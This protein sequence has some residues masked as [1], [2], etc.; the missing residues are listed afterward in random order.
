MPEET[1]VQSTPETLDIAVM[2]SADHPS[3]ETIKP[4][5]RN[6]AELLAAFDPLDKTLK[7]KGLSTKKSFDEFVRH[8]LEMRAV[9]SQRGTKRLRGEAGLPNW[10]QYLKDLI[11]E[12]GLSITLRTLYRWLAPTPDPGSAK[13][14]PRSAPKKHSQFTAGVVMSD[15]AGYRSMLINVLDRVEKHREDPMAL[16]RMVTEYREFLATE[17]APPQIPPAVVRKS[18]QPKKIDWIHKKV[19]ETVARRIKNGTSGKLIKIKP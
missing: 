8:L 19:E 16:M 18:P 1:T 15:A 2:S 5:F 13:K 9:L 3:P 12:V 17:S 11:Q 6:A 10:T 7:T 4:K 14:E